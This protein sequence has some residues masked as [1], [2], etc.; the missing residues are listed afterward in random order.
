MFER[1]TTE[2]RSTVIR[3]QQ[4]ARDAADTEIRADH[5][6]RAMA[7]SEGTVAS[8]LLAEHRLSPSELDDELTRTSRRGGLT[9]E[10]SAALQDF[11]I[12]VDAIVSK[13]ES[14]HGENALRGWED[15]RR[16]RKVRGHIP[17][18]DE[19]KRL[20]ERTL[21][22][23]LELG[24]RHIGEEHI[25]LALLKTPSQAADVLTAHGMRYADIRQVV[26]TRRAS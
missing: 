21:R 20:L 9:D 14:T 22:E 18:T 5:L 4:V 7:A 19:A 2:A 1:F 6:L 23:V 26:T 13:I 25:L 10:D 3:A 8:R 11:G 15:G 17:F 16:P 12:D 24:A